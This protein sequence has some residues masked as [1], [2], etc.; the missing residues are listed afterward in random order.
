MQQNNKLTYIFIS[1]ILVA[2]VFSCSTK[3]NTAFRRFYH[4]TSAHYN[5]YFNGYESYKEGVKKIEDMQD[6]YTVLLPIYKSETEQAKGTVNSEMDRAIKKSAKMIKLH[7]ITAKPQKKKI[8][9]R[10]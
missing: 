7:S 9:T 8:G 3:K 10:K 6:N 1:V 2:T 5:V 4:N